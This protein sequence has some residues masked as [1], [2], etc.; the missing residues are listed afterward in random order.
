[1]VQA[2]LPRPWA[3][4]VATLLVAA[5]LTAPAA[6]AAA[7]TVTIEIVEGGQ[8]WRFDPDEIVVQAGDTVEWLYNYTTDTAHTVTSTES[9]EDRQAS[10][11]F[12]GALSERGDTFSFTFDSEGQFH[13]Y[14]KPHPS[15]MAGTI[16]VQ[17]P[18]TD[19]G[20]E[21]GLPEGGSSD[22]PP[23]GDDPADEGDEGQNGATGAVPPGQ[24]GQDGE[25]GTGDQGSPVPLT[26][27]LGALAVAL[28]A[29][30]DRRV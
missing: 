20:V 26:A 10:G 2:S 9:F 19:D 29:R 7:E 13:F 27:L 1:M 30:R 8:A 6:P 22:D 17:A 16:L 25:D 18:P 14:C 4:S 11:L 3:W 24:S 23:P 12:D 28:L 21:P 5:I 15:F